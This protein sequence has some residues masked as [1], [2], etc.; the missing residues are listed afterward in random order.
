MK[1]IISNIQI[2]MYNQTSVI[3]SNMINLFMIHL[4]QMEDYKKIAVIKQMMYLVKNQIVG[5]M[6]R[7][8]IVNNSVSQFIQMMI[9]AIHVIE[10][11]VSQLVNQLTILIKMFLVRTSL[12]AA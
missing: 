1:T 3:L 12:K 8:N 5:K 11:V 2:I 4:E 6:K 7:M 10:I 9:Q